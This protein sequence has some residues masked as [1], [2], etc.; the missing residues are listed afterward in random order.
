MQA[1]EQNIRICFSKHCLLLMRRQRRQETGCIHISPPAT[2]SS[3]HILF[4]DS[5]T[6][7]LRLSFRLPFIPLSWRSRIATEHQRAVERNWQ[8][9]LN[10]A[11]PQEA[12][13]SE[14][15]QQERRPMAEFSSIFHV[16]LNHVIITSL[17][18]SAWS[19]IRKS[20]LTEGTGERPGCA[21]P[22]QEGLP[23]GRNTGNLVITDLRGRNARGN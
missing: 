12:S 11:I 1:C 13:R 22:V 5:K 2:A 7:K 3:R 19:G 17:L 21:G 20:F 16:I 15:R 18:T 6:S 14:S 9:S 10:R 8:R 23:L 4:I